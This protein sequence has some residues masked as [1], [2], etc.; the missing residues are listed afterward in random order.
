MDPTMDA[1]RHVPTAADI[2]RAAEK[3]RGV[4]FETPLLESPLLNERTGGRILIKAEVLQRTG[5]FKFRGAYNRI[6]AI[7]SH[8]RARGVVAP[9][10]GNHAQ[11]VATSAAMFGIPALIA[12]PADAPAVKVRNVRQAGA[13][14]ITFDRGQD[15]RMS[16]VRPYMEEGRILVPPFDDPLIIAG[17]GTVGLELVAQAERLGVELDAVAAPCGGGGLIAGIG[18]A[19][20]DRWP[21]VEVFGVEPDGFD[22]TRRSLEAGER[23]SNAGGRTSICDSILVNQPGELTF[24]INRRLMKA[25]VTISD[26]EA[27]AAMRDAARELKLVVEPGGAAALAAVL[28]GRIDVRGRCVAV[29]LSGGNVDLDLYARIMGETS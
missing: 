28:S 24:A 1:T 9:S 26:K 16:V 14:V 10:S 23:I 22:D 5:S 11:G 6:S 8:E 17:Q 27:A 25:A 19:V 13:Q 18:L 12:M 4:A 20:K 3:L 29:V 21:S 7:P 2:R 15:D